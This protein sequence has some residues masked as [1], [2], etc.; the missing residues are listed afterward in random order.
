MNITETATSNNEGLEDVI[1][2]ERHNSD[3]SSDEED[4]PRNVNVRALVDD[5]LSEENSDDDD[6]D[7]G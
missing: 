6:D 2:D 4:L 3:R 1:F 5:S 7:D